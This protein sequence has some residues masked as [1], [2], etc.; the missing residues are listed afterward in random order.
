MLSA[1]KSTCSCTASPLMQALDCIKRTAHLPD[2]YL[3]EVFERIIDF[4]KNNFAAL[5]VG[6]ILQYNLLPAALRNEFSESL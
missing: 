5:S 2:G 6:D 4:Q 1:I 3:P